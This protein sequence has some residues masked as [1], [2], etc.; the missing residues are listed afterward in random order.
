MN[1]QPSTR[2]FY[3]RHGQEF[4]PFEAQQL[5]VLAVAGR[6][7]PTDM[8]WREGLS[9]WVQATDVKGLFGP[10]PN[11]SQP[12][13]KLAVKASE[14]V[15][16]AEHD[17]GDTGS[18]ILPA[19]PRTPDRPSNTLR[20]TQNALLAIMILGS[21]LMYWYY[22]QGPVVLKNFEEAIA[23][24]KETGED[25]LFVFTAPGCGPCNRMKADLQKNRQALEGRILCLIDC[26][27]NPALAK[28][29]EVR[30]IPAYGLWRNDQ[31]VKKRTGYS[32]IEELKNWLQK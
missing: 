14:W 9:D 18:H 2:W 27:S 32:D 3:G 11:E 6:L 21:A 23:R 29:H 16:P 10:L 28:E 13:Q 24:A 20:H 15:G 5:R 12:V 7:R 31:I 26:S 25:V 19:R 30:T 4:G 8:V 22:S 17:S 1:K